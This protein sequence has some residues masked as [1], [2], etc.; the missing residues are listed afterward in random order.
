RPPLS[1]FTP[2]VCIYSIKEIYVI[3]SNKVALNYR[4]IWL[5]FSGMVALKVRTGGSES[6]G[7]INEQKVVQ[8]EYL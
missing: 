8:V 1:V 6:P 3:E 7:I 4:N 2:K 5:P